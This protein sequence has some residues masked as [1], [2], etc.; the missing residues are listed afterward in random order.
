ML[1]MC[2]TCYFLGHSLI[3]SFG[4]KQNLVALSTTKADYG[5]NL[6]H[7]PILC[8]NTSAINNLK[9]LIQYSRTK[10]IEIRHHFLKD[11]VQDRDSALEFV[12]IEK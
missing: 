11:H 2:V 8:D 9:N 6:N 10:H 7:I 12:S 3:S 5:I 4:Q 1:L